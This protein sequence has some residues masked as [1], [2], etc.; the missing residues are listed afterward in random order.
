MQ[1]HV[2]DAY[3]PM[4]VKNVLSA[5][6]LAGNTDV[7]H[8]IALMWYFHFFHKSIVCRRTHCAFMT[9]TD[10]IFEYALGEGRIVKDLHGSGR[11]LFQTYATDDIIAETDTT[12]KR[13]TEP[14]TMLPTQYEETLVSKSLRCGEIYD[15]Y[16]LKAIFIKRLHKFV[17]HSMRSYWN[18]HPGSALK[19]L[20][21]HATS[22][23]AL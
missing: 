15:Q 8:E 3:D 20:T 14:L 11:V 17:R 2:F 12:L 1:S 21:R 18:A 16:I 7:I 22:R 19:D 23:R 6:K 4:L 13:Y 5:F 10:P 9:E